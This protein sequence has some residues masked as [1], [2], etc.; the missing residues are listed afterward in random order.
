[1]N[2]TRLPPGGM[3]ALRHTHTREDDF[4]YI[5]EGEPILGGGR[6]RNPIASWHVRRL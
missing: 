1:V 2:L 3:S 5:L 4:I 6:R